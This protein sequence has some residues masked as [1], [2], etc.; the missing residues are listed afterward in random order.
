MPDPALHEIATL[1]DV[2]RDGAFAE[3]AEA[4]GDTRAGLFRKGG[5][6][7]A[8][9]LGLGALPAGLALAQGT[10][11]SDVKI[12]NYALT[13]EYLEAA[14]YAEAVSKG[15]LSG[16]AAKFA[17]VVAAHEAAHVD[18]LQKA[19][20][21]R[22]HQDAGVRLQGHDRRP[23]DVPE[24]RADAGGHRR[25]RLPG[26]GAEHQDRRD[27]RLGGRDPRR[28][29]A[30]RRLGAGH[31]RRRQEPHPGARRVQ[32]ADVDVAGAERRQVHRLHQVLREAE[33]TPNI[34]KLL[35]FDRDGAL[36]E[37]AGRLAEPGGT[38]RGT[39]FLRRTGALRG[40]RAPPRRC[41]PPGIASAATPKGDVDI[42]NYALTLEY[43][44]AAFYKRGDRE[45]RAERRVQAVR[46]DRRRARG[47][48]RRRR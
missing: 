34:E 13:L 35:A 5:L 42:L 47:G 3:A 14:F 17:Q 18:A 25:R 22:R 32:R 43:L 23:G 9:G 15:K 44:E 20:G 29:G 24:D 4:A 12:L 8:A 6:I 36:E 45:G 21:Q 48:A 26:P 7:A 11:K 2:D 27:P 28:R 40:R 39:L 37:A 16:I 46:Q 33:M 31:H 1:D 19:L 10:P 41:C 38:T 30:P